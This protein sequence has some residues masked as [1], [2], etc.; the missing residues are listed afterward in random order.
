MKQHF[1]KPLTLTLL[2][3]LCL[4]FEVR[5]QSETADC[6]STSYPYFMTHQLK[7]D[8]ANF[9]VG[10]QSNVYSRSLNS[11]MFSDYLFQNSLSAEEK[12]FYLGQSRPTGNTTLYSS[13]SAEYN[14]TS[15][16]GMY[17][18]YENNLFLKASDD[19]LKLFLLGNTRYKG[20]RVLASDA[21]FTSYERY[22]IGVT[23]NVVDDGK[24]WVK[25]YTGVAAV[26]NLQD[27]RANKLSISTA[28]NGEYIDLEMD[29]V[30]Y[31]V[32]DSNVLSAV[33]LDLAIDVAY[34]SA[35]GMIGF[36]ASGFGPVILNGTDIAMIDTNWRYE[37]V[38]Y[39]PIRDD[40]ESIYAKS[41]SMFDGVETRVNRTHPVYLLPSV[42][43][44]YWLRRLNGHHL[45]KLG[46]RAVDYG[47]LGVRVQA[48]HAMEMERITLYS[49]VSWGNFE[50]FSWNEGVAFGVKGIQAFVSIRGL[51]S[52][53]LPRGS[54]GIGL[55]AG[56]AKRL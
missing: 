12:D 52:V 35:F 55:V 42:L 46:V 2:L 3:L 54:S 51:Q 5:A 1:R 56:V 26:T 48:E 39:D 40:Q 21:S 41:D 17:V 38:F 49:E 16:R 15:T 32:P 24:W 4:S 10:M 18:N 34:R 47:N 25:A 20:Q 11:A 13:L 19:M 9:S 36:K 14:L 37:G 43:D 22:A 33:G 8:T 29:N 6:F 44:L 53:V 28:P 45:A 27:Y 30:S 50:G 31:L 23:H 7:W